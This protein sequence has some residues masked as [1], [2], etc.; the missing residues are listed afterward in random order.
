M[1]CRVYQELLKG[2]DNRERAWGEGGGGLGV[3][4]KTFML[5]QKRK[6]LR[7]IF[8]NNVFFLHGSHEILIAYIEVL[9]GI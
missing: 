8:K 6:E 5:K 2:E 9:Y 4:N 1:V 3:K 7:T